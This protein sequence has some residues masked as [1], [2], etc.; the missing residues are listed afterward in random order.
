MSP[1]L[2]LAVAPEIERQ[3]ERVMMLADRPVLTRPIAAAAVLDALP[4]ACEKDA[5]LCERVRR[6]LSGYMK[7]AGL[8]HAS[9]ELTATSEESVPLANRHGMRSDSAY[10]L[11]AQVYWQPSDYMIV[12]GGMLAYEDEATA[13]GTVLSFG[14]EYAQLDVGFREHWLSPMS[15]SSMLIS[16]E[17]QTMP[18][19]TLANYTPITRFGLRYEFF[20]A[21]M[22]RSDRIA[23]EDRFT[24]GNPRLAGIHVSMEP[25]PGWSLGVNRILQFGGGERKESVSD[26]I[27]AILHTSDKDNTGTSADFGNQVASFTSRFLHQGR[28]PF[29]VYFEYA[30]EDTSKNS[31]VR[32][33]NA[34]LSAGVHFPELWR[35]VNLTFET[36]EWQNGWY[37]HHIYRDGFRNEGNVI[38]HWGGDQRELL[39][40]VGARSWMARI[41]WEPGFG[42][43]LEAT[44][45][46]LTNE[47]YS[48][49]AYEGA[50][51]IE[52]RYSRGWQD[53]YV[54]GE[55]E[56]GQ[57]VFGTRYSRVGTFIRF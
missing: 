29:S 41:G 54:G 27:D 5:M 7:D 17:A 8:G 44:T 30:G 22:S 52:L 25:V 38:G 6:Y 2:P 45:R 12:N 42:G 36:S 53:F 33:G 35:G 46:S 39:E 15:D 16:T 51:Q 11:S 13:T 50:H 19:I 56:V 32:L 23:F 40:A 28:V 49:T 14:F 21:E 1:Y 37:N 10:E 26:L 3:I 55:L 24:S 48:A 34:S 20:L 9:L 31:A 43:Y 47:D 18:S 4:A 57:D